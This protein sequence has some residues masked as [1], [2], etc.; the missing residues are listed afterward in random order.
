MFI[1]EFIFALDYPVLVSIAGM[2]TIFIAL[3]DAIYFYYRYQRG[4]DKRLSKKNGH[5]YI[6][7]GLLLGVMRQGGYGGYCLSSRLAKR[8][9][10]FE[11]FSSLPRNQRRHLI[12]V[13]CG[14]MIGGVL[15][16]GGIGIM[17]YLGS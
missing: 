10:H 15:M 14:M 2:I 13:F 9:G 4:I 6:D 11:F 8:D 7:T 5:V 17:K 3:L 16:F 12:F 1:F